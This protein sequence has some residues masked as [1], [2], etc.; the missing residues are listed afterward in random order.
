MS[1]KKML[2]MGTA[3]VSLSCLPVQ[4]AAAFTGT[5]SASA[6]V[7]DPVIVSGTAPLHFGTI[8]HSAAGTVV[9]DTASGRSVTGGVTA[10]TGAGLEQSGSVLV[11]GASGLP[12]DLTIT[13]AA[14]VNDGGGNTMTVNAFNLRTNA[15]GTQEVVT[16]TA[17]GTLAVPFGGTLIVAGTEPAGTYTGTFSV[18]ANYQ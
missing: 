7:I 10:I 14:T 15:G 8:T 1:I 5:A 3:L 18:I 2:F 11:T 16:L 4:D 9:L 13:A 17:A 6:I 12:I